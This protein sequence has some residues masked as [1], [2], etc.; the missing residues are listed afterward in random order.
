MDTINENRIQNLRCLVN[1][2]GSIA[3]LARDYSGLDAT[4]ISQLLNGHRNFG[5]K[6][7][8]KMELTL[9]FPNGWFDAN[10]S[11]PPSSES[12]ITWPFQSISEN[13]YKKLS[14]TD[15]IEIEEIIKI[16]LRKNNC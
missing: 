7:A 3:Q 15:R 11:E 1:K 13:D 16:K 6:A 2:A 14:E 4:Y 9:G 5:E 8:R 10:H 12:F